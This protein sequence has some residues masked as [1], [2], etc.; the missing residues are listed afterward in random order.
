MKVLFIGGTGVISSACSRLAVERGVD[1]FL[2]NRGE[3]SRPVPDGAQVLQCDFR[4]REAARRVLA[5]RSF[6]AVVD[7][8]AFTPDQVEADIDLFRG[9][10]GQYI[11]ISTASAYQKPPRSLPITESTALHN[12]FWEYSRAKIAGEDRL[13]QA[14]RREAFPITIAK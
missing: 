11:F 6:D 14:Y 10:T 5:G 9:R 7:W 8:I 1:L 12:P 3:T 2:L 4:D 13:V